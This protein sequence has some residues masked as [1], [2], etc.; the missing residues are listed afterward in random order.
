MMGRLLLRIWDLGKY[1]KVED[2]RNEIFNG[3]VG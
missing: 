2:D 3:S 1:N